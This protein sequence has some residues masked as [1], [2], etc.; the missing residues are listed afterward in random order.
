[1][2]KK[3]ISITIDQVRTHVLNMYAVYGLAEAV[4]CYK[5]MTGV[6]QRKA[7]IETGKMLLKR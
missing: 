6:S 7:K 2:E 4:M 5:L 3:D 1:M